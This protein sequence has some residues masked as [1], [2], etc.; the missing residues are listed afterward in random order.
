MPLLD[1]SFAHKSARKW[2]IKNSS[3][4]PPGT[5]LKPLSLSLWPLWELLWQHGCQGCQVNPQINMK[6]SQ[7][8]DGSP[9][10]R[11]LLQ[12]YAPTPPHTLIVYRLKLRVHTA[13]QN[14]KERKKNNNE[15]KT[16]TKS[17]KISNELRGERE[18]Y[19]CVQKIKM[20]S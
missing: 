16:K 17:E 8:R 4:A 5:R 12:L 2:A 9:Q 11:L 3:I 19:L 7:P 1:V 20:E 15:P 14:I 10:P 13:K 18:K 6:Q